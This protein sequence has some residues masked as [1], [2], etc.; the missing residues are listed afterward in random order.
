MSERKLTEKDQVERR[1]YELYL[2]RGARDG[3]DLADWLA[4]E[5]ELTELSQEPVPNA[6][7]GRADAADQRAKATAGG[8]SR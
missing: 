2:E 5:K 8:V 6:P 1:A 4:A 7:K 3:Q